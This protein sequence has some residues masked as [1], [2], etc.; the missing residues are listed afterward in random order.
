[1]APTR[2]YP[3]DLTNHQWAII[4]PL[5]PETE[6]VA[7]GGRPPIHAKREIVNAILYLT[8]SGCA[9]RMLPADFPHWRTVYGYFAQWRDDGTLDLIHDTLPSLGSVNFLNASTGRNSSR[10]YRQAVCGEQYCPVRPRTAPVV[11][12]RG[13]SPGSGLPR[14]AN[15]NRAVAAPGAE[16]RT[17]HPGGTSHRATP[18]QD[19]TGIPDYQS[20]LTAT[21]PDPRPGPAGMAWINLAY[22]FLRVSPR[23]K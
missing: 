12:V 4:V 13:E 20:A 9:W 5:L 2:R 14:D 22:S 18:I 15:T 23:H 1:M 19:A 16:I 6:P 21:G 17:D 3:T 10:R 7:P 8:R 11:V